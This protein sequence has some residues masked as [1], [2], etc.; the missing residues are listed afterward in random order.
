MRTASP[1]AAICGIGSVPERMPSSCPPPR[2]CAGS[3][4]PCRI[5]SAPD[6]L[7]R[8][9]LVAAHGYHVR[10]ERFG[11]ER[12]L[13]K[14]LH[15][16]GVEKRPGLCRAQRAGHA[17]D[18]RHGAGLIVDH[19]ERY[20]R[21]ILPERGT[22]RI[23]GYRSGAVGGEERYLPAIA[24][25]LFERLSHGVVLHGGGDD[26]PPDAPLEICALQNGPVVA[27]RAAG[28]EVHLF[29]SAPERGSKLF[30]GI[31]QHGARLAPQPVR[32]AGVAV[33]FRHHLIRCV[34]RLRGI[35]GSWRRYRD[36]FPYPYIL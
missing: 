5:Y 19:H 21:R 16:V 6:A 25:E 24:R 9:D 31:V 26:V 32:R 23:G 27:L 2:M 35:R 20:E 3:F 36:K 1:K 11:G 4:S 30:A 18:V 17:R 14:A 7:G 34:R 22:H 12:L 10:A 8:V 15:R 29:G 33:H 13:H 28:G